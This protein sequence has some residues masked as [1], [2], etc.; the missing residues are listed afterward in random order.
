M[1]IVRN[2]VK[3]KE[4][5]GKDDNLYASY[6]NI[7]L[8]GETGKSSIC[9]SL[10]EKTERPV[11]FL[12]PAGGTEKLSKEFSNIISYPLNDIAEY[13]KILDDLII[14][15]KA[16]RTLTQV[17]AE[18][19]K[20]RLDKAKKHYGDDW[21]DY[22]K[23][24][25]TGTFPISA[26]V[27]EEA[28]TISNWVQ[29]KLDTDLEINYTGEEKARQGIDW[30]VLKREIVETFS[31]ALRLPVTTIIATGMRLPTEKQKLQRIEPDV[32]SGAGQR[33]LIDLIGNAFY[34]YKENN[35]YYIRLVGNK[36]VYCKDKLLP[37]KTDKKLEETVELTGNPRKFWD[38][39]DSLSTTTKK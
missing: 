9:A 11:L 2:L 15:F 32:A 13:H 25:T 19:D 36:D 1:G 7:L 12:S 20:D 23:M 8:F 29:D 4:T 24:A 6:K 3:L 5:K 18:G 21:D 34:C 28:S 35:K 17:I 39:I 26:V 38:Y 27:V 37:V 16:I 14:D 30:N 10:S 33:I 31:K 22:Y